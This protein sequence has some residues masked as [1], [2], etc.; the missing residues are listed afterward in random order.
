MVRDPEFS[1]VHVTQSWKKEL[2]RWSVKYPR[3]SLGGKDP[4]CSST[5]CGPVSAPGLARRQHDSLEVGRSEK[6]IFPSCK[7]AM[8]MPKSLDPLFVSADKGE[9]STRL[10]ASSFGAD[11]HDLLLYIMC[12]QNKFKALYSHCILLRFLPC[13]CNSYFRSFTCH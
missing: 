3:H 7:C 9:P 11:D 12:A 10:K 1:L 6:P 8:P 4:L 13:F 5:A 2:C